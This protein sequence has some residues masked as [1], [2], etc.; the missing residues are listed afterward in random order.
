MYDCHDDEDDDDDV[1]ASGP[2]YEEQP[3]GVR[4]EQLAP[5]SLRIFWRAVR[6]AEGYRIYWSSSLGKHL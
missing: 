2:G 4:T 1:C 6:G 5:G 3:Q